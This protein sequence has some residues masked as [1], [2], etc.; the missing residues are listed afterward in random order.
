MGILRKT[1]LYDNGI[2]ASLLDTT[3]IVNEAIS[4]HGLSPLAAAGLGRTLTACAFMASCMKSRE[5]R[6]SVTINGDG[7]GGRI[8]VAADAELH[9]RGCIDNPD[10]VLPLREDGKLNVGGLVGKGTMTVVRSVGMKEPYVGKCRLKSGEI[11]EDF[12]AYYA[13]SEQQPTG[14]ALGVRIGKDGKCI[15]AGGLVLQ[16]LP[17]CPEESISAAEALLSQFSDVSGLIARG[18]IEG[19]W[20]DF[21]AGNDYEEY[22]PEYRC[23]CSREYID[24]VL[25]AL[26]EKEL[27]ETL[28]QEG[29]IEVGCQFCNRKYVYGEEEVERL[30]A[31]LSG[32]R[33]RAEEG[34]PEG[35]DN[36]R[37]E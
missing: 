9:V 31:G 5:D 3:D 21:F 4:L 6:L 16:P 22:R 1:L 28:A 23:N 29:K 15:G 19:V 2:S 20:R 17:D 10:A 14:M 34:R 11:A 7:V 12:A 37:N 13:I 32:E 30:I 36:G 33:N 25:V 27:R 8:V 35:T 26:G 18:G 24:G